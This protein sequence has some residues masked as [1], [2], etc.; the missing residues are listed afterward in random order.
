[1][2]LSLFTCTASAEILSSPLEHPIPAKPLI[3][4]QK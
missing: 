2:F 1:M 3:Q 4:W